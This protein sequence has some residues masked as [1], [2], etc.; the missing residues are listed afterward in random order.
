MCPS[1]S[2]CV[3]ESVGTIT[4]AWLLLS[5]KTCVCVP[6]CVCASPCRRKIL[7]TELASLK[8][9]VSVVL[10]KTQN[11]DRLIAALKTELAALRR[12]GAAQ[13]WVQCDQA[14]DLPCDFYTGMHALRI[15]QKMCACA[16]PMQIVAPSP[17][18]VW[19]DGACVRVP[20]HACVLVV[21][22][23]LRAT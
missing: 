5:G 16:G 12:T 18:A 22:R 19:C 3:R 8:E 4:L 11:D 17:Q 6:V 2:A 7:E 10:N 15:L 20:V 21:S 1:V 23:E 13:R 14:A 9:K